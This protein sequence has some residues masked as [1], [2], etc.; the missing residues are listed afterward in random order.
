[1]VADLKGGDARANFY[2]PASA[3]VAAD[4]G[5][6]L[7]AEFCL[8]FRCQ[9]HIASDHVFVAVAQARADEFKHDLTSFRRIEADGLDLPVLADAVEY[10]CAGLH[11][12][13]P[14]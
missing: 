14:K 6:L 9:C 7:D 3:F 13:S 11:G 12:G 8:N 2:D 1:M 5:E 10:C 4:D